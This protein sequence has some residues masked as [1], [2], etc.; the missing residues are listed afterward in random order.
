MWKDELLGEIHAAR[1]RVCENSYFKMSKVIL[2]PSNKQPRQRT[3][4]GPWTSS[5]ALEISPQW[6]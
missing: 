4:E 6:W 2:T 1:E 3:F 5:K